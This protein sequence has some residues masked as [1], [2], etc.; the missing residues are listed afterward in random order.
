MRHGIIDHSADDPDCT[1]RRFHVDPTY[2]LDDVVLEEVTDHV[3]R[4]FLKGFVKVIYPYNIKQVQ[5]V[6]ELEHEE[7]LFEQLER[8]IGGGK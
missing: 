8:E 1:N 4:A 6:D 2:S 5:F 7:S 3:L